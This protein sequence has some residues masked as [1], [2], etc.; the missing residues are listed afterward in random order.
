M[1]QANGSLVFRCCFS[2]RNLEMI[3]IELC[4]RK[5]VLGRILPV[6]LHTIFTRF[7]EDL[8]P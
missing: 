8:T 3:P 5:M 7:P 1:S 6:I 2:Q 4:K